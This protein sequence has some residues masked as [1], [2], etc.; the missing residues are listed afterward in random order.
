MRDGHVPTA[1]EPDHWRRSLLC[2]GRER[3]PACA[4]RV[5]AP[6][7]R[8]EDI[9]IAKKVSKRLVLA[10]KL[11]IR[12]MGLISKF[13]MGNGMSAKF[14]NTQN[15]GWFRFRLG[16]F[17]CTA[18]WDGQ[19]LHPYEG[20]YPNADPH[21]LSRLRNKYRLPKDNIPLDLNVL[22]VNTG[23]ELIIVDAGLGT[24]EKMFGAGMGLMRD[25][26]WTA[27]ID[28]DDIDLV[29]VT[30]L[31][32]D[33]AFG[34][35]GEGNVPTFKNAQLVVA[36]LEWDY[37]TDPAKLE[38]NDFRAPWARGVI[39]SVA[40]YRD[41]VVFVEEG[42]EIAHGV[43]MTMAA[44]HTVGHCAY[45][46]ESDGKIL[47]SLG[48][49]AHHW[50]YEIIHPEWS[51]APVYDTDPDEAIRSKRK[52]Y[53]EIAEG[54]YK[55]MAYHFPWPGIGYIEKSDGAYEF[56]PDRVSPLY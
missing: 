30:H 18:I 12:R 31:H 19:L 26:L 42:Q 35:I 37:W 39:A 34:I 50:V 38:L 36:K 56:F 43:R 13:E 46:F 55:I 6:S 10:G 16:E 4:H 15:A 5:R 3:S 33:H 8:I 45:I 24:T 1:R 48:D 11:A 47:I 29:L 40:P 44:G 54:N 41:R 9:D 21:E 25:N 22:V 52:L 53:K 28:P 2:A 51:F 7:A 17:E 49:T 27:G 23:K 20:I 32:P 14:H